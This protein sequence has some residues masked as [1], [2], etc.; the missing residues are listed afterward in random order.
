LGWTDEARMRRSRQIGE[1]IIEGRDRLVCSL[2]PG[3]FKAVK[4]WVSR[5]IVPGIKV[6]IYGEHK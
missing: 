1:L 2:A 6:D 5:T 4:Q 3:S